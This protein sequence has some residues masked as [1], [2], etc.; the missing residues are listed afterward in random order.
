MKKKVL[1]VLLALCCITPAV[2]A[3]GKKAAASTS[4]TPSEGRVTI[5]TNVTGIDPLM[6]D[7]RA[8]T[9][10][11]GEFTRISTTQFL[12]TVFSE[13]EAG[14][15]KADIIQAP[16]P[17]MERLR[18]NGLLATYTSP[19]AKSY[20]SWAKRESEGIYM[21]GIEYV[22][23]L[24]NREFIGPDDVPKRY[25]DLADPKWKDMIVMPDPSIHPTTISWLVGLREHIFNNNEQRWRAYLSGLS[26]NT[27]LFVS[28]FSD[29]PEVIE[30]GE[31]PLGIS[32]PKYIVTN[33]PAPLDW[34]RVEPVMGSPRAMAISAK[35]PHPTAARLFVDYW[36]SAQAGKILA[37]QVGEYVLSPGIFPPI[38]G[39]DKARV[40]PIEELPDEDI[41]R[42]GAEFQLIFNIN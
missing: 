27:P 35:A 24:Y 17:V 22:S 18:G 23:I 15:L 37:E 16:I 30:N 28:S 41:A 8:K 4:R 19:A 21:Y 20:P 40:I 3:R 10:I 7:L 31:R 26:A 33:A 11:V 34:A 29:T 12:T 13:F 36:L 32:V 5:Y 42:W 25:Q 9:G 38:D 39:M 2:F 6:D 14:N 1:I